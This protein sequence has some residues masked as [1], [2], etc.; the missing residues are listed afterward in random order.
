MRGGIVIQLKFKIILKLLLKE[1]TGVSA[2]RENIV[3]NKLVEDKIFCPY[4]LGCKK[5][6]K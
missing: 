5:F 2:V 1:L 3:Q 6:L 4:R